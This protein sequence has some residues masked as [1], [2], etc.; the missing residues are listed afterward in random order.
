[1]TELVDR[2]DSVPTWLLFSSFIV[3]GVML[4][5]AAEI[6]VHKR[7][8]PEKRARAGGS[9]AAMIQVLAVFYAVLVAFLIVEEGSAFSDASSHVSAEAGE[10]TNVYRASETFPRESGERLQAAIREYARSAVNDDLDSVPETGGPSDETSKRLDR[11]FTI[12]QNIE[13]EAENSVFYQRAVDDLGSVVRARR[14]RLDAASDTIPGTLL[15]AVLVVSIIVLA[16]ALLLD[17]RERGPHLFLLGALAVVVSLN[18][19]LIVSLDRPFGGAVHVSDQP[20]KTGLLAPA[21][22]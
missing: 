2:L 6:I 8:T 21:A 11:L 7:V 5:L 4:T 20:L 18:L 17:T 13:P 10:L 16:V 1:V 15:F 14:A 19:A 3:G 22:R 12:L 9:T